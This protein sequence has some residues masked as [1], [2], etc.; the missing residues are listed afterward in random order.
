[1]DCSV[2]V[3]GDGEI[4][5]SRIYTVTDALDQDVADTEPY[6]AVITQSI[7]E[8]VTIPSGSVLRVI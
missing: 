6:I 3:N 7:S 2:V 5:F 1:M 8:S 4:T